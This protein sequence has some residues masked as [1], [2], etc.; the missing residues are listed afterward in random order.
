MY[1]D[2]GTSGITCTFLTLLQRIYVE[3]PQLNEQDL[4]GR[5]AYF[6]IHVGIG[7]SLKY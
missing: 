4:Y 1:W 3:L 2:R 5:L 6:V 7:I